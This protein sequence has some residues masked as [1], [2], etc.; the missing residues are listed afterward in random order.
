MTFSIF[1]DIV[2]NH[3]NTV[4]I[5]DYLQKLEF[6]KSFRTDQL[7]KISQHA[8]IIRFL[9]GDLLIKQNDPV[10]HAY[11]V[12]EGLVKV[13]RYSSEGNPIHIALIGKEGIVGELSLLDREPPTASVQ[14]LKATKAIQICEKH[15]R[16]SLEEHPEIALDLI[17]LL[18]KR[19]RATN[20]LLESVKSESLQE[21]T[22]Q[23]IHNLAHHFSD[24]V[25]PL[26]HEELAE[27]VGASRARVSEALEELVKQKI[28]QQRNRQIIVL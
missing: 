3:M 15:V 8:T 25:I 1:L 10:N 28:I 23:T 22:L 2:K 6:F 19:I 20:D 12:I 14:A 26:S 18:T 16:D 13:F 4:S 17:S 9:P 21:R 27:I 7:E 11:V 24:G 5:I